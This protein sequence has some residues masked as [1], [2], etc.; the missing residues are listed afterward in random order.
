MGV[1][2]ADVESE[3]VTPILLNNRHQSTFDLSESILPAHSQP[4]V[5]PAQHRFSNAVTVGMQFL[6]T[7]G[8]RTDVA[9]AEN[10]LTISPDGDNL[11]TTGFDL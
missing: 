4:L 9:L 2:V 11:T 6:E 7:V 1:R 3:R 5:T 8:L 10:V